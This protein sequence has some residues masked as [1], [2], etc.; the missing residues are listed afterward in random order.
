SWQVV[1]AG[2]PLNDVG[3]GRFGR[4]A[5]C[6]GDHAAMNSPTLPLTGLSSVRNNPVLA[7]FELEMPP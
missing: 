3:F 2:Q 6:S 5:R 1:D 7:R 4:S